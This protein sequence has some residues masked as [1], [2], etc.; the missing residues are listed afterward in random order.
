LTKLKESARRWRE[1]S[2]LASI[3]RKAPVGTT[4]T[5]TLSAAARVKLT[6]S[7]HAGTNKI[8]FQGK[9]SKTRKLPPGNYQVT[10]VSTDVF[11]QKSKPH[12]LRFTIV[13]G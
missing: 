9:L 7:G 12:T 6:F 3:A 13:K 2:K 5:F 4:F 11:G 10:F 1:G 8:K